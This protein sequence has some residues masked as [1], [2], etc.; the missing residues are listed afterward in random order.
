M[1][2]KK[3]LETSNNLNSNNLKNTT[4]LMLIPIINILT[5]FKRTLEYNRA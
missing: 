1:N 2:N 4:I 3:V 5:V